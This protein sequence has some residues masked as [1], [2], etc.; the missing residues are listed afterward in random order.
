[1][2]SSLQNRVKDA[3]DFAVDKENK[4]SRVDVTVFSLKKELQQQVDEK[5]KLEISLKHHLK[6]EEE[7]TKKAEEWERKVSHYFNNV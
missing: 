7:K 6:V 1:M 4:M 2:I 3:E 5:Q